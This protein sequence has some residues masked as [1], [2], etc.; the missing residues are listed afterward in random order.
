[1]PYLI[2]TDEAGYG[3]NFGPLVVTATVWRVEAI[4]GADLFARL[5]GAVSKD[6]DDLEKGCLVVG[7]SKDLYKPRRGL[8]GL[9]QGIFP[10]LAAVGRCPR[11]WR[12]M[13]KLLAAEDVERLNELPW[14]RRFDQDLP[15]DVSEAD[16]RNRE[17]KLL[18][19]CTAGGCELT[20]V[21]SRV[22]VP[23][24]FNQLVGELGNKAFALSKTT[25]EL[26]CQ[27]LDELPKDE[28]VRAICDKHGGRNKYGPL[29]NEFFPETLAV[30][31]SESRIESCYQLGTGIQR[32]EIIFRAKAD[33][34]SLPS[35]LASMVSKYLR[36][37]AM[38]AF[39]DFW[40]SHVADLRPTAGYPLDAKRFMRQIEPA[41]KRLG[42]DGRVLWRCR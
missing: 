11:T 9:E 42:I 18:A 1:M 14:Y 2:G 31:R 24:Q 5:R 28:P 10:C 27:V 25:L 29:L 16:V 39:N 36:E 35:A 38:R 23:S 40:M 34:V 15:I 19:A 30:V 32:R 41:R 8:S 33:Q 26:I 13:W 20:N 12:S 6:A 7:D 22:V 21:K 17:Q 3:P 37:L 4:D